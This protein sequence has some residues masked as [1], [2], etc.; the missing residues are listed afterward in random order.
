M[1]L[2]RVL[3]LS[4]LI[5]SLSETWTALANDEAAKDEAHQDETPIEIPDCGL[6]LAVSSTTTAE[7]PKWGLYAGRT[8]P[9]GSP[10]G[11]GEVAVQ[12]FN[13][14]ANSVTE[15]QGDK[16]SVK[17]LADIVDYLEQYLWVP[18]TSGG[19]FELEDGSGRIVTAVPGVGVV[20]GYNPKSTNADWNHSIAYSRPAWG[21]HVGVA[22]PGRGAS[23]SYFEVTLTALE[24]IPAGME[25]FVNYGENWSEDEEDTGDDAEISKEDHPKI[26]ETI[27]KMIEFF[28][29]H[30][31]EL[32]E[33][34]KQEIYQF[35]VGDVLAAAAGPKKGRIIAKILPESPDELKAL[36]AKG[37][38]IALANP[39]SI[40]T[41][42][43]LAQHGLCMDNLRPG[44]STIP[45]AGRGAFA[46][47]D[48][49]AGSSIAPIPLIQL[50]KQEIVKMYPLVLRKDGNEDIFLRKSN[51]QPIGTQ[52]LLNYCLGHPES[53]LLFL[54]AG[55]VTSFIN[56]SPEPNAKLVWS[57]HP[58]NHKHWFEEDPE[59]LVEDGNQHLGLLMEVIALKEI[60]EGEEV[61][62]DYGLEWASAW[63]EHVEKWET[64]MQDGTIGTTWPVRALDYNNQ[65]VDKP[66]PLNKEEYPENLQVK[67]FLLVK[68][69][70]DES[71][72][73][74]A[75]EKVRI[76]TET[77]KTMTSENVFECDLIDVHEFTTPEG[78]TSWNYTVK[79]FG[80]SETTV[81]KKVPHKAIFFVDK[82]GTSDQHFGGA[83]RHYIGIPDEIFPQGPWRNLNKSE[84]DEEE[85]DDEDSDDDNEE[86]DDEDEEREEIE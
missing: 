74:E 10:I 52:L 82:S 51:S 39:Q 6:Y 25:I 67:A 83:F 56:H 68:K 43:W 3:F 42:P 73:N 80:K 32:D 79:W 57:D 31:A 62:I 75:G 22:H 85:S 63:K 61:T 65:F 16:D 50:P 41:L 77:A 37:G 45:Y 21:E 8:I 35:L 29:K 71:P 54:P 24:K 7:E 20:G 26:D 14:L 72:L 53:E 5:L 15:N 13:L 34:S 40:R 30:D 33:E 1:T 66:F 59:T 60:K 38:S 11:S 27:D 47:R 18:Q 76:W 58:N 36:K 12:T 84:E 48:L 55:A 28:E 86:D 81:V 46:T 17:K 70:T 78:I 69:P 49:P 19:Q 9:K 44:P 64:S 2:S 4:F 23:S